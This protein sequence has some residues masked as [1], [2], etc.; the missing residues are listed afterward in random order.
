[1]GGY[2][3]IPAGADAADW[4]ARAE[5]HVATFPPKTRTKKK[6]RDDMT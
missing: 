5:A 6:S 4:I 3:T 2:L 1:M